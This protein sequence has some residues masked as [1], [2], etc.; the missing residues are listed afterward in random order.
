MAFSLMASPSETLARIASTQ[1]IDAFYS[2]GG[3]T[4]GVSQNYLRL[5]GTSMATPVVSGAAALLIQI[6]PI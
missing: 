1:V 6:T 5:S 4:N 3:P 2:T